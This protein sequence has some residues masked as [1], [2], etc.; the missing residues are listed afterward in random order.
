MV[1]TT[2]S[3]QRATW[4]RKEAQFADVVVVI[5]GCKITRSWVSVRCQVHYRQTPF[6]P[7]NTVEHHISLFELTNHGQAVCLQTVSAALPDVAGEEVGFASF[8]SDDFNLT[9]ASVIVPVDEDL[10]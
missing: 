5:V 4:L 3:L 6:Q 7:I 2:K 10:V 1:R 9:M 8:Y